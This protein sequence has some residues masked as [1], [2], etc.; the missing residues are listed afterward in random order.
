MLVVK[1][2]SNPDNTILQPE[3]PAD[4]V[5]NSFF[6]EQIEIVFTIKRR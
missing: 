4:E 5:K 2:L 6:L 1:H 3:A